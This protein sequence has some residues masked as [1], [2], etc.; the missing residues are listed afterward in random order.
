MNYY[1]QQQM[2]GYPLPTAP[3]S[4]RIDALQSRVQG[5]ENEMGGVYHNVTHSQNATIIAQNNAI[6]GLNATIEAVTYENIELNETA[7]NQVADFNATAK[8]NTV[9]VLCDWIMLVGAIALTAAL[10]KMLIPLVIPALTITACVG[11]AVLTIGACGWLYNY[12][13]G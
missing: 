6:T 11:A 13:C 2:D 5:L 1:F 4:A 7:N 8:K 10:S 3:L 9:F 12:C